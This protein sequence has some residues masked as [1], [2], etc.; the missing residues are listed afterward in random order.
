[1]PGAGWFARDLAEQLE[2]PAHA[3][4]EAL[5]E[6]V[7]A[8][9]I[10]NDTL[11]PLRARLGGE[12]P[13]VR[14]T[15]RPRVRSTWRSLRAEHAAATRFSGAAAGRWPRL[16]APAAGDR[17]ALAAALAVIDRTGVAVRGSTPEDLPGGFAAM[18]QVLAR[19]EATGAVRRWYFIEGLGAAQFALTDA[20]D[21]LRSTARRVEDAQDQYARVHTERV[22]TYHCS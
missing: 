20:V 1:E 10:T 18:Y 14:R 5:W 13:G 8:G 15:H 2:V 6:L 11:A 17:R 4:T 16:T 22:R 3:L 21:R 9:H 12:R 7:W 19:V